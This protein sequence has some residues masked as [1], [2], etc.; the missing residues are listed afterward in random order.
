M[1]S[2]VEEAIDLQAYKL[3]WTI[4]LKSLLQMLLFWK[5]KIKIFDEQYVL[6]EVADDV[7]SLYLMI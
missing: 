6:K 5:Q 7:K 2:V 1:K 4:Q 3:T